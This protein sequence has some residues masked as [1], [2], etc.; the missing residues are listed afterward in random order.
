M[1]HLLLLLALSVLGQISFGQT[2]FCLLGARWMYE[3]G[4]TG[5]N[6]PRQSNYIYVG[7]TVIDGFSDVRILKEELRGY[8]PWGGTYYQEDWSYLRQSGDSVFQYVEGSFELAFDLGVE[9][10]DTRIVYFSADLCYD[11]D[12][13]LIESI[14]TINYQGVAL[15]R[16]HYKLLVDDQLSQ[17][18]GPGFAGVSESTY[19]ERIG[20][21]VDHPV[22]NGFRCEGNLISEYDARN[23]LCY[24]DNEFAATYSDT[25]NLFLSTAL[26]EVT[27]T[28][29]IIFQN[30]IL[31]QNASSS[32]L[33]I[34]DILG[35]ELFQERIISD[36]QSF[37]LSHLP[38][39]IL[40]V[41]VE[42]GKSRLTEKVVKAY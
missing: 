20:F 32:T 30:Q 16:Y 36:N 26:V 33:L 17:I 3:S 8:Y 13:M 34:Y 21:M 18:E 39:G 35:K 31:V 10:G 1:R 7:D 6:P 41:V 9:A 42:S 37:D 27:E 40:M 24:T 15:R 11:M 29:L 4:G 28:G 38:N 14:D 2:D 12:T 23:F 19:V 22:L 5:Q 25:C